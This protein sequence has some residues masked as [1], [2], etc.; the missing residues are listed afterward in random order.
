MEKIG[1]ICEY[2]PF[3]KG[4]LYHVEKIREMYPDSLIVLVLGGYFLERGEVSVMSKWN[5]TKVALEYGVDLILELPVLYGTN[6]GD[7]FAHHAVKILNECNISKL[8]FGSECND[9]EMLKKIANAQMDEDFDEKVRLQLKSGL[10]YPS[11]LA[12]SLDVKLESNDLLGVSYIKAIDAINPNIEPVTIKRT[13]DFNDEVSESEI[14]S[15]QNIRRK[16]ELGEDISKHIP[17]YDVSFINDVDYDKLFELLAFRIA[18]DKNL[19]R[20]LGVDEGL[21]NRLKKSLKK[22]ASYDELLDTLKTKRYTTSRLRRMLIHIALG[23]EKDDM[24]VEC[25]KYRILGFNSKGKAYLKDLKSPNLVY[26]YDNRVWEIETVASFIYYN[27]TDDE[28]VNFEY[29]N[30]PIIKD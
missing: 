28:S 10:N 4:H 3:H 21:E 16:L 25:S 15:A 9:V 14:V 29:L 23:I 13:N 20:Y 7:Y 17:D 12:T 24:D 6:S 27:L 8:V 11:S 1:I 30:K 26:K 18:T 5:K 19:G 22:V 2:N